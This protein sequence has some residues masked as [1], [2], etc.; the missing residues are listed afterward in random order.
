MDEQQKPEE[1]NVN[2][3]ARQPQ[4]AAAA[5]AAVQPASQPAAV[6]SGGSVIT[7]EKKSLKGIKV[8]VAAFS[9]V[10]LA[11]GGSVAAY[12]G[13]IVPNKPENVL[14][15]AFENTAKQKHGRFEGV[16][17]FESTDPDA[18]IKAFNVDF[19]GTADGV[20]NDF[21]T[22]VTV[23]ASGISLPVELRKV[24][25]SIYVKFGDTTTIQNFA[26]TTA[27]EYAPLIELV[28]DKVSEQ[29]IE[30]DETL[31]KQSGADCAI[32]TPFTMTD[33]D[34]ELIKTKYESSPFI[35]IDSVSDDTVNG[36]SAYKY[37]L[38]VDD[39]KAD[40]FSKGLEELSFVKALKECTEDFDDTTTDTS[41]SSEDSK[42]T[43]WVD[44]S[45]K[46]L[47]K[48]RIET[49]EEDTKESDLKGFIEMTMRYEDVT[50]EKPAGARPAMEIISELQML[51][52]SQYDQN[53]SFVQGVFDIAELEHDSQY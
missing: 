32:N 31:L 17:K 12:L 26:A 1:N 24:E 39:P 43:L 21:Q 40:E 29:W 2:P 44:K 15:A 33:A 30:I 23:T 18:E 50:I 19:K 37:D 3:A 38:S 35:T 14:K 25:S 27:P 53:P 36:R 41:E 48:F 6:V 10:L 47:S 34:I 52:M 46:T 42:L 16:A 45:S 11:V 22:E 4:P 8:L 7:P 51:L 13:V 20:K 49:T 9:I 28:G 5:D